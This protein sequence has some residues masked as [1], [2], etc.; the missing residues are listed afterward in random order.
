MKPLLLALLLAQQP[1]QVDTSTVL[2][3]RE[4]GDTTVVTVDVDIAVRV[5]SLAVRLERIAAARAAGAEA[6]QP[7]A[8]PPDW[9]WAGLL[10][11]GTAAVYVWWRTRSSD[12]GGPDWP[13]DEPDPKDRD[14][15]TVDRDPPKTRDVPRGPPDPHPGRGRGRGR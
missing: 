14:W 15:P 11:L 1:A 2:I 4:A 6:V 10:T 7:D 8:G 9:F 3:I 13:D 12:D 5:D